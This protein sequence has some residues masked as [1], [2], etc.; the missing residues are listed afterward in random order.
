[1]PDERDLLVQPVLGER[2]DRHVVE[3]QLARLG[4]VEALEQRDDRRLASAAWPAERE[5]LAGRGMEREAVEHEL[6][7]AQR[8][9][10]RDV[11][12]L[13]V[14]E[15][16]GRRERRGGRPDGRR[17]LDPLHDLVGGA[18]GL[19]EGGEDGAELLEGREERVHVKDKGD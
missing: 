5:H 19:R 17:A 7:W 1:M 3:Q 9:S 10:K 18:D 13:E 14:A 16:D 2:G 11:D 6:L 15:A 8:I 12:E 4:L